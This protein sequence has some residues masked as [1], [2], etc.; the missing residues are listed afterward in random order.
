VLDPAA[1]SG[2]NG[3]APRKVLARIQRPDEKIQILVRAMWR[4]YKEREM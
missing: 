4:G 2:G 1:G 3:G